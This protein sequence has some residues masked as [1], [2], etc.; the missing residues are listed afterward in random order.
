MMLG[1]IYINFAPRIGRTTQTSI[2]GILPPIFVLFFA[3]AGI[4]LGLQYDSIIE[5]G[6]LSIMGIT[7]VFV[8]YRI[9]GKIA[10]AF[11]AGKSMNAPENIQKYLGYTLLSQAGVAIGLAILAN[12]ELGQY[13]NAAYL[14]A[15]IISVITITT[16]FF[17]I[18]GPIG[19]RYGLNKAGEAHNT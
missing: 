5:F 17:E 19:V 6:L 14:G 3:I 10:G 4:E 9:L 2:E 16:I 11:I 7:I 1:V 18:L 8:V 12:N 15:I 13:S